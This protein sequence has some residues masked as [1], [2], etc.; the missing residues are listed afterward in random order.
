MRPPASAGGLF[1][2]L[3]NGISKSL[4]FPAIRASLWLERRGNILNYNTIMS[5]TTQF[6][7]FLGVNELICL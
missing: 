1:G 6:R 4:G 5:S 3:Q 7:R 2:A